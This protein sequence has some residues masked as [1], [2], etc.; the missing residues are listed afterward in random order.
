MAASDRR[1]S[2]ELIIA[3]LFIFLLGTVWFR[4]FAKQVVEHQQYREAS[5]AQ[6]TSQQSEPGQRGRIFL[7]DRSGELHPVTFSLWRYELLVSPRQVK[8]KARLVEQLV[9]ALPVL[10]KDEVLSQIDNDKI[11]VPAIL[12]NIEEEPARRLAALNL[13]GVFL[14]PQLIRFY[15]EGEAILSQSLGFVGADGHGKY[16]LEATY[17]DQLRGRP[18]T[19]AIKKD[20]FGRLIN[21]L[22]SQSSQTGADLVLTIDYNLQFKVETKLQEAVSTYQADGGTIVVLEPSSGAVLALANWPPYDPNNFSRLAADQQRLF[23]NPATSSVYEPGSVFK[24]LTMAA[25]LDAGVVT[26]ETTNVFGRSVLISGY[27]IFNAEKKVFGRQNMNQVLENSDNVAMTWVA[28]QLGG[29]KQREYLAK[30]GFGRPTAIDLAGE[31]TGRLPEKNDW[32]DLLRS[33]AAFGQGISVTPIQLA[34]SYA[35]LVNGGRLVAPH[36]VKELRGGEDQSRPP[37][38]APGEQVIKPESSATIKTMLQGVV[39][40]GHGKRAAIAGLAVGGKTGT[41]QV[42]NPAGGYFEDRHTGTFTG[43]FPVEKPK[44][45]MLVKLDNPKTVKFAESSAAPTFGAIGEWMAS[46]YQLR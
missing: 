33:T 24:P 32:N 16:G 42:P 23:I 45:V 1:I 31:V 25:A 36:L 10:K 13:T 8:N 29:Q 12:K 9:E 41:A 18:G 43:F 22:T 35:M 11:Y 19:S 5:A 34:A 30:F 14:R 3:G 26:P 28:S 17:D 15:P 27:E 2:R 20:S 39:E 46:Y 44:F 21:V 6:S 40:R 37:R 38:P 4:L 7:T